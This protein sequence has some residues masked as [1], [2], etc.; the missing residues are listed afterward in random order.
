MISKKVIS[1]N[2]GQKGRSVL[3]IYTGGTLGMRY[4]SK[5]DALIPFDFE[6]IMRFVPELERVG[7]QLT[8]LSFDTLLDSADMKPDAWISIV[9]TIAEQYDEYDGF[10][11]LHGTDT[12]AFTASAVSFLMEHLAKPVIFT[13]AQLP[14]GSVRNDA[15]ENLIT[16][17]QIASDYKNNEPRV[18]EVAIFFQ[19][20]LLRANRAKKVESIHF[21]AFESDNYPPLAEA[22]IDLE[23]N[24][25]ALAKPSGLPFKVYTEV[26]TDVM[27]LKL[28]PGI[29]ASLVRHVLQ[30]NDTRAV[31]METFGSGNAMTDQWFLDEI[32]SAITAGKVIINISQCTGGRV[33]PGRYTTYNQLHKAGVISGGDMTTEAAVTKIMFLLANKSDN[34]KALSGVSLRGEMS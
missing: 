1:I 2:A 29:S 32:K 17:I 26:C 10:V 20:F 5:T 22:G 31:V 6:E 23:Y 33:V 30:H 27:L 24:D 7:C 15:R 9:Q 11:V 25:N 21:D 3:V 8:I 4:D 14:I 18:K 16:A 34:V 19:N 13:G 12:M 28:F